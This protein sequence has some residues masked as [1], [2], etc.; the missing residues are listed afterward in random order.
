MGQMSGGP[1]IRSRRGVLWIFR[2]M[3]GG[4]DGRHASST[5]T[6]KTDEMLAMTL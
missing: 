4:V 2:L 5:E 6:K 3:Y 1:N